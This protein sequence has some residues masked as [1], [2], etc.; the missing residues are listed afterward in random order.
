MEEGVDD[1]SA[2]SA[3]PVVAQ[4]VGENVCGGV[5]CGGV[6]KDSDQL[7]HAQNANV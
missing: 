6:R 3:V 5:C 7:M 2:V 1:V 4:P